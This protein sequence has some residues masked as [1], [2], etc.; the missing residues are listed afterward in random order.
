[1]SIFANSVKYNSNKY[2]NPNNF[3]KKNKRMG[4]LEI[5]IGFNDLSHPITA[6]E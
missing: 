2:L 1:M 6:I 3:F 5:L 4:I